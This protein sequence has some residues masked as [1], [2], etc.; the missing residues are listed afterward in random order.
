MDLKRLLIKAF[1]IVF[2]KSQEE[3]RLEAISLEVL[4]EKSSRATLSISPNVF[5]PLT[6]EDKDVH[7]L[8]HYLKYKGRKDFASLL[9]KVLYHGMCEILSDLALFQKISRPIVLPIPLHKRKER[10]RGFNQA[11]L[12]AQMFLEHFDDE[13][14]Y[15]PDILIKIKAT[16]S[17]TTKKRADR[18]SDLQGTFSVLH[19]E[20][21]SGRT[22]LLIDDV[23][24]TGATF[25][26]AEKTLRK[27]GADSVLCLAVAH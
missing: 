12:I 26:E 15:A 25:D 21:I 5:A 18:L 17:Q 24:T 27:A 13:W 2:P 8:I 22:I 20:R 3:K 4:L 7:Q 10:K 6:Y 9:G 14:E 11:A 23:T 19:P 1:D 16:E